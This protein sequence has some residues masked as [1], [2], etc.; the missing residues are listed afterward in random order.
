MK[1]WHLLAQK[2]S[3]PTRKQNRLTKGGPSRII[4]T[5][6]EFFDT[7]SRGITHL[8]LNLQERSVKQAL[9]FNVGANIAKTTQGNFGIVGAACISVTLEA[10]ASEIMNLTDDD[11]G[12]I[13]EVLAPI[14]LEFDIRAYGPTFVG[15]EAGM[16]AD[17]NSPQRMRVDEWGTFNGICGMQHVP[18]LT[19]WDPGR[20]NFDAFAKLLKNLGVL[21]AEGL[22]E[23]PIEVVLEEPEATV[24]EVPVEVST[25][26][27]TGM[28]ELAN[29][30]LPDEPVS[31]DP[32][33][34]APTLLAPLPVFR[35]SNALKAGSKAKAVTSWQEA[36]GV[37]VTGVHNGASIEKTE[38]IQA[39]FG[40][41]VTGEIDKTTWNMMRDL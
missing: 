2:I 27:N 34:A 31:A 35:G 11:L 29:V 6:S 32:L 21:N 18:G 19:R 25:K 20:F 3:F 4:L 38:A 26:A 28:E 37:P 9:P 14:C 36:V 8:Y 1:N 39:F 12:W 5:T 33:V 17:A 7:E 13:A 22:V 40:L 41:P 24:Y 23:D 10:R 16:I 15:M 30:F